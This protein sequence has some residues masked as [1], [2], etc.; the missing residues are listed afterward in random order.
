MAT[1]V[2]IS[3]KKPSRGLTRTERVVRAVLVAAYVL[4]TIGMFVHPILPRVFWTMGL[5]L[6]PL[7][8]VIAGFY[9]WR[10]VCPLAFWG[11]QG[12]RL[13]G[14]RKQ[15]RVPKWMETYYPLITL[16]MLFLGLTGRLLF[17]NGDGIFLGSLL[18]AL[19]VAAAATNFFTTGKTWCNFICPVA[20]VERIYTEPNSLRR[21][22]NSQ[23]TKCTAC[24]KNCPDIDQENAY[25]KD[26]EAGSRRVAYFAFPGLVTGFYVYFWLRAGDW[27]AYYGGGWTQKLVDRDLMAGPG[28][29]F[30]P[31]IPAYVAAPLS[32]LAFCAVSFGLF[33]LAERICLAFWKDPELTRHRML[34]VAGF[35][36]FSLF[37][38]WAGQPTLR[39]LP[40]G[41]HI[42]AFVAPLVGTLFLVKRLRRSRSDFM[43]EKS[44]KKL[45]KKWTFD[46]PPPDDTAGVFAY[47]KARE[48][49]H[50]EQV[51]VYRDTVVECLADGTLTASELHILEQLR[52][53]LNIT[54]SEHK[55]IVSAL[56]EEQRE[57]FEGKSLISV[58][59]ELQMAGY[60][61]ALSEAMLSR[62]T[63]QALE[64]IR[65]E[66]GISPEIHAK[67]VAELR[68]E[69]S[70]LA[71]RAKDSLD[72]IDE[73]RRHLVALAP[74]QN[75]GH[76]D[77][78]L[79]V[80]TKIQSRMVAR[81]IDTLA[82]L[83][84]GQRVHAAAAELDA[85]ERD[86]REDVV[87]ALRKVTNAEF[88][89]RLA[90][91]IVD[92]IPPADTPADEAAIDATITWML[93][94]T[95]PYLRAG[96]IMGIGHLR[97]ER[98][99]EAV[100]G[101]L[102]DGDELVRE[103]AIYAALFAPG[104][105]DEHALAPMLGDPSPEI[106][107]AAR[108]AIEALGDLDDAAAAKASSSQPTAVRV[109]EGRTLPPMPDAAFSSLATVDRMLFLRFV[110]LFAQLDPEDLHEIC[111][112][113][114]ERTIRPPRAICQQGELSDE[115][116]VVIDGHAV[117]S[118]A[119]DGGEQEVAKLHPGDVVGELAAIDRSP[120]SAS[121]KPKGG[122][123]RVLE[124][125]GDDFRR[126]LA[127]RQDVA[128][129]IMATLS[130]RL[131]ETLAKVR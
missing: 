55:K 117:V 40:L 87:E 32:L 92:P 18:I 120:R 3:K 103:T 46:E 34:T 51:A 64:R 10:K 37:Y 24:K 124:I 82:L 123:V 101:A 86:K 52:S 63:A 62:G 107:R 128:P 59:E 27:E 12:R 116:Y 74:L 50:E 8:I 35:A 22:D 72:R 79:L 15:R 99:A 119:T 95:S 31:Q 121:V 33:A 73:L 105:V 13:K 93:D 88:V 130:R 129:R 118:V 28:F 71:A 61:D 125:A 85:P 2:M 11:D 131:R 9:P 113:A 67:V 127:R 39:R 94:A 14:D 114:R 38:V 57:A 44:A 83:G 122:P 91:A 42:A 26:V 1:L 36:A 49:A 108:E 97:R 96:A 41:T 25:W 16:G 76:F 53:Q 20:V 54:E 102:S 126:R 90:P 104:F 21:E 68:G 78:A 4:I 69:A 58:E 81:I 19:G 111:S 29:F 84:E 6:L 17:T 56:S 23:C 66:Y 98:F 5:P 109:V 60:R 43:E 30:A 100:R 75:L 112:Y 89:D 47:F 70:P 7:G 48:Q 77:F 45:L 106:R 115:L 110:P 65:R 80:I